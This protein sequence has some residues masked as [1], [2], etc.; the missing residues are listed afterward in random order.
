MDYGYDFHNEDALKFKGIFII[1]ILRIK[2][3]N[4]CLIHKDYL[5]WLLSWLPEKYKFKLKLKAKDN[6]GD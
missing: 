6:K 1:S 2:I 4:I 3:L 5:N